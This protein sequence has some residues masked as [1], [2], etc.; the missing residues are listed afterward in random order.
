MVCAKSLTVGGYKAVHDLRTGVWLCSVPREVFGTDWSTT[1]ATDSLWTVLTID[2]IEVADSGQVVFQAV[3]GGKNYP[4][5]AMDGEDSV[6]GH[7][8][9]TWLPVL[10]LNGTFGYE[11]MPGTVSLNVP[12]SASSKADMLAKL[13]WRG[14]IT[15]T[16]GKHKRNYHIKFVDENGEKTPIREV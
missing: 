16:D 15:N 2:N 12:D 8:T 6:S 4:F 13:K 11:Y 7:I 14:G 10:E 3:E 1:V 9:F 5:T